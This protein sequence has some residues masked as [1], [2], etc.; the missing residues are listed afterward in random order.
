[1][2]MMEQSFPGNLSNV[3][4]RRASNLLRQRKRAVHNPYAFPVLLRTCAVRTPATS[5][6]PRAMTETAATTHTQKRWNLYV[7]VCCV[8]G[9][10]TKHSYI[11][12]LPHPSR[13]LLFFFRRRTPDYKLN[14]A[15]DR[16][17]TTHPLLW[18]KHANAKQEKNK[19]FGVARGNFRASGR[20][21]GDKKSNDTTH[22]GIYD[23]PTPEHLPP[24]WQKES[25]RRK[26]MLTPPS[27]TSR[28][29]LVPT[30]DAIEPSQTV[31]PVRTSRSVPSRLANALNEP[32]LDDRANS[33]HKDAERITRIESPRAPIS[34]LPA[35]PPASSS[36][37]GNP[38][39]Q[40]DLDAVVR[41]ETGFSS[42]GL[43]C[44][45]G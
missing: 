32:N 37:N 43:I 2:Y 34:E 23:F 42:S 41:T 6:I 29:P 33:N 18:P 5:P 21:E 20:Y 8:H 4:I 45:N 15:Y 22:L 38:I 39:R 10:T 14:V 28:A 40:E 30:K 17:S 19:T 13:H 1:M 16:V 12:S 27:P 3:R 44:D 36:T 31:F 24:P 25:I 9:R 7:C 11:L 26:R 35:P